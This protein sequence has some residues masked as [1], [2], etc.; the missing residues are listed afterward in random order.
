MWLFIENLKM[1]RGS[2]STQDS[3]GYVRRVYQKLLL[4]NWNAAI[5][6]Q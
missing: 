4:R 2:L 1:A 3:G 5:N 6:V